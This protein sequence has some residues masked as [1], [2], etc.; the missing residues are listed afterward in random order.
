MNLWQRSGIAFDIPSPM[1]ASLFIGHLFPVS[2]KE[3]GGHT[4]V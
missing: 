4:G 2:K 1:H 3:V